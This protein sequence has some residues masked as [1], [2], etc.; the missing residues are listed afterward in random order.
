MKV[1]YIC[2]QLACKDKF[3]GECFMNPCRHTSKIDHAVNFDKV[4]SNPAEDP[5]FIQINGAYFEKEE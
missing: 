1:L 2:D 4:V 5:R 3:G